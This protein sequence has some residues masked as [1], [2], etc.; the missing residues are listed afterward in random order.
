MSRQAH[1]EQELAH[2]Q[3]MIFQ[4]EHLDNIHN[5]LQANIV[6]QPDYWRTR[7][8]AVLALPNM[9]TYI[10]KQGSALLAR[11]ERLHAASRVAAR[12]DRN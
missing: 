7:I 8:L 5:A 9:P 1:S 12:H 2:I 6:M 11:L 4:L 10:Q 3:T